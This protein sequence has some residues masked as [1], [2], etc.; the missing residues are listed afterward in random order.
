MIGWLA[1]AGGLI[2]FV[3]RCIH[4]KVGG[5]FEVGEVGMIDLWLVMMRYAAG[6]GYT[7]DFGKNKE[8]C[9]GS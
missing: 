2:F 5:G 1:K 8:S 4:G 6:F 3:T 7:S 9:W